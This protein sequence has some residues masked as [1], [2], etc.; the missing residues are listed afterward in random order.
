MPPRLCL[1][2]ARLGVLGRA[3][4]AARTPASEVLGVLV[5]NDDAPRSVAL[6][7]GLVCAILTEL[8][9][10]ALSA[11]TSRRDGGAARLLRAARRLAGRDVARAEAGLLPAVAEGVCTLRRD[12][13]RDGVAEGGREMVLARR[14]EGVTA[15]ERSNA[16]EARDD[17]LL[18]IDEAGRATASVRGASLIATTLEAGQKTPL[19]GAHA[20]YCVPCTLPSFLPFPTLSP[21][22]SRPA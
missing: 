14:R 4:D 18:D 12:E 8:G 7:T 16:S 19:P 5:A 21:V 6:R 10:I 20:K 9:R 3:L 17:G 22:S 13:V 11:S 1:F 2:L 15:P